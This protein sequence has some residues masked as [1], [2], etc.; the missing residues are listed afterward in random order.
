M[1]PSSMFNMQAF[2]DNYL[3]EPT[4]L[5]KVAD[6]GS[7]VVAGQSID[8]SYK[9]LFGGKSVHYYGCDVV[10]GNNVDIVFK[11]PYAWNEIKNNT[12]DVVISGQALEHVEYIWVTFLEITRILKEGG[13]CCIIVP[14]SGHQHSFPIDCWRF[15]ED[16]LT[17]LAKWARLEVLNVYA[18][19][20][21][22]SGSG[23]DPE[24]QDTVLICRKPKYKTL[25]RIKFYFANK[26]C[27]AMVKNLRPTASSN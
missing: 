27:R 1:H 25:S 19:R 14:S 20:T 26:V 10:A 17:A 9:S 5:I 7:Q 3:S 16:G 6:I 8:N 2:I 15:N 4:C 23:Y 13:L 24:W 18:N 12:F 11:N 22:D 21:P